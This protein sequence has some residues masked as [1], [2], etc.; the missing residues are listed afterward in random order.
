MENGGLITPGVTYGQL[1]WVKHCI[2]RSME[3]TPDKG[4]NVWTKYRDL[5]AAAAAG[6]SGTT[7]SHKVSGDCED[8]V[9]AY[10]IALAKFLDWPDPFQRL[11]PQ[12]ITLKDGQQH[13]ILRVFT[14]PETWLVMDNRLVFIPQQ[15]YGGRGERG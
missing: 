12:E 8:F 2:D 11:R 10:M 6:V 15:S 1:T 13:A 4:V 5:E 3:W 14:D 7:L 9:T